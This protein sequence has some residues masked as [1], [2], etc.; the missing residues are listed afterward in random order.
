[1]TIQQLF[2]SNPDSIGV[3]LQESSE[4]LDSLP[5]A[6]VQ[7]IVTDPPYGISYQS[8]YC[9]AGKRKP[10]SADWNFQIGPFLRSAERVLKPGGAI[11]L[12]SRWDVYPLWTL[13][14][15]A[16]L[17]LKNVIAWVKDNHSA[18]DLTGNFGFKWEAILFMVKG[19]HQL[20]GTRWPNAWEFPRV[21][22]ARQ[23]H[24]AEKPVALLE[25]AITASSDVG[26][27]VVDP[28]CGSG[29][30]GAA[31]CNLG[32]KAILGDVDA[33]YVRRARERLGLPVEQVETEKEIPKDPNW[34][35]GSIGV[36]TDALEGVHPEDV[37][38]LVE[39]F[40]STRA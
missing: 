16:E 40:R 27:M 4:L 18:G 35:K 37:A 30:T 15:P 13:N 23:I 5:D 26:D 17:K 8:N 12:F 1:M 19:R 3:R 6:S 24:P 7:L 20:R 21:P 36:C 38:A 22:F 29:S 25:R 34:G 9:K 10:I 11:Y 33:D 14:M 2:G 39:W 28:F 31:A 32:R